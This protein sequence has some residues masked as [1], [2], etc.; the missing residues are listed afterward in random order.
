VASPLGLTLNAFLC[1]F[2]STYV[3]YGFTSRME[4]QLDS[5]SSEWLK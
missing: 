1:R 2:F 3:D 4:E 5:I